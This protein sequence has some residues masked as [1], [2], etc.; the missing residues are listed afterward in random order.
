MNVTYRE[1]RSDDAAQIAGIMARCIDC[2][3]TEAQVREEI[4][5]VAAPFFV[6]EAD[7]A[8]VGFLSGVCA[9]DE[10]EISD[11]AVAP[12]YRRQ[13]VATRLFELLTERLKA[14]R[15]ATAFLL[16]RAD[17]APAICLYKKLGFK[18]VG[19]RRGYYG[20]G[21]DAAIMRLPI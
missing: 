9:A 13:K 16:V 6:A 12:E 1:A 5:N 17:N 21:A 8:V 4:E 14:A 7:G 19:L 10:C 3:W 20:G 2:P 11:I 18:E 15:A